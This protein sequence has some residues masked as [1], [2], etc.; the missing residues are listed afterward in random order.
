MVIA[1]AAALTNRSTTRPE[2]PSQRWYRPLPLPLATAAE[3]TVVRTV[4]RCGALL[5]VAALLGVIATTD[6]HVHG[7][8]VI[9]GVVALAV[10]AGP[11]PRIANPVRLGSARGAAQGDP[12]NRDAIDDAVGWPAV[13]SLVVLAAV[14]LTVRD[15]RL[16]AAVLGSYLLV[17]N[18]LTRWRGCRWPAR[19]D[20]IEAVSAVA[21]LI[22]PLGHATDGRL[23]WRNP[24]VNAAHATPGPPALWLTAVLAALAITGTV[25]TGSTSQPPV[26]LL[27]F[28]AATAIAAA[29][30]R[31]GLF[32][33]YFLGAVGP[34]AAAYGLLTGGRWLA[35]L[36]L[37][38][39]VALHA[40]AI[41]V[42][43]RQAIARHDPRT[44]RAVQ[45]LPRAAVVT[46]VLAGLAVFAAA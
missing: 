33:G 25:A 45:F 30:L 19:G 11:L 31:A 38:V 18:A 32:R 26:P 37:M 21:G 23:A 20:A 17:Q 42:M 2:L 16:L 24:V 8:I 12:V 40:L 27:Q 10:L 29:V 46:S 35:P 39:F 36:D 28:A 5:I 9:A 13:V 15:G 14:V 4:L 1:T 3:H 43:H 6:A 7:G 44:S 41:T 34:I 22:A